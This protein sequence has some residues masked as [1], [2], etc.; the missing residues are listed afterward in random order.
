VKNSVTEETAVSEVVR[1]YQ[2]KGLLSGRRGVSAEDLMS[3]LEISRATLKRDLAK[4]R[5][6]LHVPI[7]F[8]RD[9][10]GYVL[11]N[12][13]GDTDTELPGLWF[14]PEEMLALATIQQLLAQLAPGILGT[15]LRPIQQ[16]LNELIEKQ[17]LS[18]EDVGKRI[19][20]THS[21]GKRRLDP[22]T[23]EAVA[24]A[25]MARKR[26]RVQH[27]N[28]QNGKT[29]ERELSPQ[30]IVHYRDNWYLDAWCHLR[31]DLRSFSIDALHGVDVLG[32]KSKEIAAAELD[33]VLGASYG[34]FAGTPKAWA[35]LKFTP[36]RARWVR[37][38][39]W[40]PMQ[41]ERED[42]DGSFE[43]SVP[44]SDEREILGDI[45][46]YGPDVSVLAP[47]ELRQKVQQAGL[48]IVSRYV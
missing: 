8:D 22:Q 39:M 23:F 18:G 30:R 19:R 25:T 17:G 14:S 20:L 34:I 33:R 24:A 41:E 4:L 47:K 26:L 10:G 13:Q 40:H 3:K 28:R 45:L 21:A 6:Q 43:L 31:N 15:K 11:K 16:R 36:D 7:E 1:L 35:V 46:R 38:E 37:G 29:L 27:F 2:Y 42:S 32:E 12:G 5:D 44:Y 9:C 48:A